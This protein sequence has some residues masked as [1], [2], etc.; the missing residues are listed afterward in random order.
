M[1]LD[2]LLIKQVLNNLINNSAVAYGDQSGVI[3]ISGQIEP[4]NFVLSITDSAGG[5]SPENREKIFTPF[6]STRADGTGLGLPLVKKIIEIHNGMI[7]VE[8]NGTDGTT[9]II[10]LPLGIKSESA[11]AIKIQN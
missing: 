8:P 7:R 6:F 2:P 1:Q 9:F 4:D 11:S 5:I 10:S 3:K